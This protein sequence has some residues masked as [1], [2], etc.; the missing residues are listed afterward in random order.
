M[1]AKTEPGAPAPERIESPPENPAPPASEPELRNDASAPPPKPRR[2]RRIGRIVRWIVTAAI[3]AAAVFVGLRV[4]NRMQADPGAEVSVYQAAAAERRDIISALSGSGTLQPADSYT[5][6]TLAEGEILSADFS[7]GDI[8]EKDTVLYAID[9]SGTSNSIER[10]ELTLASARTNYD[11]QVENLD[12][13]GVVSKNGGYA[14]T[15]DVEPGDSV[16][17]GQA[18]I[19]LAD[20]SVMTV[21]IPFLAGDSA[22]FYAG[23]EAVVTLEDS[24]ETLVG[25][26]AKIGNTNSALSGNVIVRYVTID[27][28]N[29]GGISPGHAASAE[30]GGVQCSAPGEFKYKSESDVTAEIAGDVA[31]VNVSE[32]DWVSAG[33][34]VVTLTS[35]SLGDQ[36]D[37]AYRSVRDAEIALQNQYDQLDSFTITSPISGTIVEKLFKEGDTLSAGKSLCT[38]YDMSYLEFTM[39]IDELDIKLIEVGQEVNVTADAIEGESF[40]GV[41]TKLSIQGATSGGVT[42]YPVTVRIDDAGGLLPGMN[43]NAEIVTE[44]VKGAVAVPIAA[45]QRGNRV[46]VNRG[47]AISELTDIRSLPEGFELVEVVTGVSD[48]D[49]IEI[50]SG[51]QEGD[52]IVYARAQTETA[53][54][55][56]GG[57]MGFAVGGPGSFEARP[58]QGGA[59]GA[60]GGQMRTQQFGG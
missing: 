25:V 26:I 17:P 52:E 18:I 46:I 30:V 1:S 14:V 38:I 16:S 3:L 34:V 31:V 6:T 23:Q 57:D 42:T 11:R 20:F 48:D 37:S 27:V 33:D 8:V 4:Y 51:L 35:T 28:Q 58:A 15:V 39:N 2:R 54:M 41:V 10:A 56:P 12:K 45:V 19:H 60:G 53:V 40:R 44:S 7:E 50:V 24:F 21:D 49:Y 36:I 55:M 59:G 47:G 5:V 29:P 43:I 22:D 32:G 9:S 13:L